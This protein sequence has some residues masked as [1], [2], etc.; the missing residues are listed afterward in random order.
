MPNQK[1]L[2]PI[3]I[4]ILV[5]VLGIG[6]YFVYTSLRGG[7][8]QTVRPDT[9]ISPST[10]PTTATPTPSSDP[11]ANWKTYQSANFSF[12]YPSNGVVKNASSTIVFVSY[13]EDT[14]PYW[15]FSVSTTDNPMHLSTKQIVDKIVSD[16]K[17]NQNAPWAKSQADQMSDTMKAYTN[18]QITGI[19]LQSFDEGY[20]QS[21]GR[22]VQATENKIYEFNIGDGSGGGVSDE[23]EKLFDQI[24]STFK[25]TQ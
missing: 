12:K 7:M 17:S 1:G 21:F 18:G 11:T 8:Y 23:D 15:T 13:Q 5:A 4:V 20:P 25:F 9:A 19:K 24:L 2:A 6:G 16:L 3:L 14:K 22:V 10:S